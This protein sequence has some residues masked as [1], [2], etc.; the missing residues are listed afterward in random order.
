M[1][2]YITGN[3]TNKGSDQLSYKFCLA[4]RDYGNHVSSDPNHLSG[5]VGHS[6]ALSDFSGFFN[7]LTSPTI[8]DAD[9]PWFFVNFAYPRTGYS[10][11]P[12]S[13]PW[14]RRIST[15]VDT[16][17]CIEDWFQPPANTNYGK[18]R[19]ISNTRKTNWGGREDVQRGYW[20]WFPL[21]P[22][23]YDPLFPFL[24]RIWLNSVNGIWIS[25]SMYLGLESVHHPPVSVDRSRA[26][27]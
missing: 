15:L 12:G 27:L 22:G 18:P 20:K 24:K 1:A 25:I 17:Q 8:D 10:T 14:L 6:D 4:T 11:Q 5:H 21:F 16:C 7:P 2:P 26:Y 23:G 9:L 19:V 3:P 13:A